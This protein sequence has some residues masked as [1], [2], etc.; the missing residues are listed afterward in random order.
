MGSIKG[1]PMKKRKLL[2]EMPNSNMRRVKALIAEGVHDRNVIAERL[3]ITR[4]Q[5]TSAI[6]NLQFRGEIEAHRHHSAGA[7]GG[8]LDSTYVLTGTIAGPPDALRG[9]NFIFN[10]GATP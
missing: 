9:V 1:A 6:Y 4:K 2:W 3:G 10:A 7:T 8:R 5:V